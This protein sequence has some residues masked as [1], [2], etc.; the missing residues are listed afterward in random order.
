MSQDRFAEAARAFATETDVGAAP[1]GTRGRILRRVRL[2]NHRR[3][4]IPSIAFGA[5][6]AL[7]GS[8]ALATVGRP[9]VLQ[10]WRAAIELEPAT[11][12]PPMAAKPPP[13]PAAA[14]AP[15]PAIVPK[16]GAGVA[17]PRHG[18]PAPRLLPRSRPTPPSRPLA[19]PDALGLFRRAH[20]LHFHQRDA[21]AALGAW[22]AYLRAAPFGPLAL[23]AR[24]NRALCLVRLGRTGEALTAL[25]PFAE[26][27]LPF[28]RSAEARALV[29]ALRAG[30][31]AMR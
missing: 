17:P 12:P 8:A 3:A 11:P 4:R 14:L 5:A 15:S 28:Y 30:A 19:G 18:A 26:G 10:I 2:A 1:P 24:Y 31:P 7:C 21:A 9:L 29:A 22:D 6:I 23:E 13:P 27:T 25:V 16:R 20:R